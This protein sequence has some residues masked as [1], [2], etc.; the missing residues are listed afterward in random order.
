MPEYQD[1]DYDYD[2]ED[3]AT[4][5]E[6]PPAEIVEDVQSLPPYF[7][8]SDVSIEARP[9]DDVT[10]NCDVRNFQSMCELCELCWQ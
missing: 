4:S 5:P 10:I 1:D 7:D 2:G 9:G 3:D 6:G 8:Q